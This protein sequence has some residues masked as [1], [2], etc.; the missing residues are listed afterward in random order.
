MRKAK[1]A[2]KKICELLELVQPE[3]FMSKSLR[4][5]LE[6]NDLSTQFKFR[7]IGKTTYL[8]LVA[9]E[10]Y[11]KTGYCIQI[12]AESTEKARL[13]RDKLLE[14]AKK[15]DENNIPEILYCGVPTD[16]ADNTINLNDAKFST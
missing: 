4:A 7:Q 14:Y 1:M 10:E 5:N 3:V 11:Y 12:M 6:N 2:V 8:I 13:V 9:L 16:H 15:I